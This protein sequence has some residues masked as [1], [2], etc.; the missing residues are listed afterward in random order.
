MQRTH[1]CGLLR[2]SHIGQTVT[3]CGWASI[4]RDQSHQMFIDLRDRSGLVQIVADSDL[5]AEVHASLLGVKSEY[6]L[7]ITGEVVARV[8]GK[9]NPKLASGAVEVRVD[10][11]EILNT[12]K[13]LPFELSGETRAS[14]DVRLQYRYLDMRRDKVRDI[15][16]MRYKLS[17]ET[18]RFLDSEGFW[19][20]E[21]PLLWKSTPEGAREY[22]VPVRSHPG[23]GFVLPQSPQICKQLLMVGGV[24]K[25]FQIARCFR[26]ESA[27]ADRQPEFTQIDIEMS[28]VGQDDVLA[29]TEKLFAHLMRE[30]KSIEIPLPF[31]RLTYAE[32]MRRFGSDKPD[33]RFGLELQDISD[34]VADSGFKVF[35]NALATGGQ[36]KAI[37][38]PGVAAYS[39]KEVDELTEL[40][41]RFGARGL[42]T[43]ALGESEIKSNVAKF[44][45]EGQMRAIFER[46]GANPGDLVLVVADKPS[47]VAQSLDFLRREM[48]KRLG[49]IDTNKFDFLWIVDT[50]MFEYD[51]E[52]GGFDATHHPFCLPNPEDM[53]ML[54]EGFTS[55]LSK[56]DAMHPHALIRAWLYDLVLNGF[57]LASG[58]IRCHRREIQHRIF[59]V[60]GLDK[61]VAQERFG[62]MLDAFEYGAPPH[63]GIAPGFD[64]VV[65]LL[66]GIQ[67]GNIREVIPFPKTSGGLD[68]LSGAPTFIPSERWSEMGLQELPREESE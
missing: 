28:F 35:T 4:V 27:R 31:P 8:A 32:S 12:S 1:H 21:T 50:P 19:E 68:P 66:A 37:C 43:F 65:T 42:A 40:V 16:E 17:R 5:N 59:D 22:V 3:L 13:P 61:E 10:K 14:E 23:K 67:D 38:A 63:G 53:P 11:A 36:V 6:C 57:E 54:E 20:V 56:G 34:L 29:L 15:L 25:Y 18:R 55:N 41:K 48:A 24:E 52:K 2:D 62:F 45:S 60:I 26:D 58:S 30:V 51:A 9:E 47:V 64:R 39:R 33:T 44:F 46:V 7:Q 49:L